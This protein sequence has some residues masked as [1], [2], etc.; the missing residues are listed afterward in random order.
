MIEDAQPGESAHIWQVSHLS[1]LSLLRA[2][3]ITYAFK[4]HMHDYFVIG[5]VEEGLRKFSYQRSQYVTPPTGLIVINPGEA[6]TG[7][8]AVPSIG[9][10]ATPMPGRDHP[11]TAY[12]ATFQILKG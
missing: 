8:A 1:H 3:F 2:N 10:P 7:E 6:H 12:A 11:V 9:S 4:R 5:M